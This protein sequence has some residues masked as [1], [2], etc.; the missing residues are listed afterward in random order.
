MLPNP[1]LD[2]L[3]TV[4]YFLLTG[5]DPTP[6]FKAP[7]SASFQLH[8]RESARPGRLADKG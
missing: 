3:A 1:G 6:K 4:L 7:K 2:F 8:R 5:P